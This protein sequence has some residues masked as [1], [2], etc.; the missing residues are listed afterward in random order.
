MNY[1]ENKFIRVISTYNRCI[2]SGVTGG[3]I[4]FITFKMNDD[5]YKIFLQTISS[6]LIVSCILEILNKYFREDNLIKD[7]CDGIDSEIAAMNLGIIKIDISNETMITPEKI[8][9]YAKKRIDILHV[10]GF[11]WTRENQVI[12]TEAL[13]NKVQV[14]VIIAD[15]NNEISM[16]FYGNHMGKDIKR[17]IREVLKIWKDIYINSQQNN[18]LQ[19]YLFDGAITHALHLN[20]N[21]VVIKSIPACKSYSKGNVTT[22]YSKKIEDGIYEKFEQE[23][24]QIVKESTPYTIEELLKRSEN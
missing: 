23:I 18:N 13:K 7:I 19:I 3:I 21:Y 15:F 17:E 10:Y 14:R 1:K 4:L 5:I 9:K 20:E 11:T 16:K 24:N 12:L 6:Y 2:F 8:I 22:I